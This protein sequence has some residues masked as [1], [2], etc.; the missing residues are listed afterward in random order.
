MLCAILAGAVLLTAVYSIPYDAIRDN[1]ISS[2]EILNEEGPYP[3]EYS[4]CMSE[5]DNFTDGIM[6]SEAC[7]ET[8]GS[9]LSRAMSSERY[10]LYYGWAGIF[11]YLGISPIE[12]F[13]SYARYWHGYLVTLKPLLTITD[14]SGIRIINLIV[15]TMLAAAVCMLMY[16]K[17]MKKY[18]FAYIISICFIAPLVIAKS[19]QMSTCYYILNAGCL[20]VLIL[21]DKASFRKY[22][23]L[24]LWIGIIT[25]YMDFLT[26]PIATFGMPAVLYLL[27]DK[28]ESC[29]KTLLRLLNLLFCWGAGYAVMW[30]SKWVLAGIITGTNVLADAASEAV[31]WADEAKQYY[32]LWY[33]WYRNIRSFVLNPAFIIALIAAIVL[34]I[35]FIRQCAKKEISFSDSFIGVLPFI[36][37]AVLPFIWYTAMMAHSYVHDFFTSKALVMSAFAILCALTKIAYKPKA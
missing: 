4:W 37:V 24:F 20:A 21:K 6:L 8:E 3:D 5:L 12:S 9:A 19:L 7:C 28:S 29:K 32:T 11:F 22:M 26:Y 13:D 14:Y 27:C 18:I 2:A 30:A 31:I 36:A 25:A 33:T 23:F 34:I 1:I 16:K 17:G 10:M 15:Q 35:I